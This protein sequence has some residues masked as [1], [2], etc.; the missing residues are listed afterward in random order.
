MRGI[1]RVRCGAVGLVDVVCAAGSPFEA[2]HGS[3]EGL[4]VGVVLGG[5][6]VTFCIARTIVV[7]RRHLVARGSGTM[8]RMSSLVTCAICSAGV[9]VGRTQCVGYNSKDPDMRKALVSGT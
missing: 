8:Y 6:P 5:V 1:V 4:Y 7:S 9:Y 3:V 2:G